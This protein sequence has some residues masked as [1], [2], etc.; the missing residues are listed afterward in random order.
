[1]TDMARGHSTATLYEA[2]AGTA[3]ACDPALR[4]AWPGACV[5]GPAFTVQG[6]GGDNLA[7]H[8]AVAEAPAGSVLVVDLQGARHG[9]WGEILAVAAQQR[10]V[11][12]LVVDG[13]VRD[14]AEQAEL[15]FPV[16][17]RHITVVGTGK[18][19]P[20]RFASPV[21]V[22]DVVVHPGDL[23]VGDADG[24]VVVPAQGVTQ[25]LDRADARVAAEQR[26]LE[27]IRTG[28]TTLRY[29]D[30]PTG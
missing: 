22:A 11:L 3:H 14:T 26:A 1:M 19:H 7:L 24:V 20:G 13:G 25:T 15:G 16:F 28:V 5:A 4:A 12:G 18:E 17:A 2:S 10:G 8:R 21:R 9:H 30:L 6:I 29:Y 27:A 23:V